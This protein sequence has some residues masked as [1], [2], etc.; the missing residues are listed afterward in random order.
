MSRSYLAAVALYAVW[1]L[2]GINRP[3]IAA[4]SYYSTSWIKVTDITASGVT[5]ETS[6]LDLPSRSVTAGVYNPGEVATA[7]DQVC[8]NY[9]FSASGPFQIDITF[10]FGHSF[11]IAPGEYA[12]ATSFIQAW[13][14]GSGTGFQ[15][16]SSFFNGAWQ[17][18][19]WPEYSWIFGPQPTLTLTGPATCSNLTICLGAWALYDDPCNDNGVIPGPA[20]F[21]L[22]L[23]GLATLSVA[24]RPWYRLTGSA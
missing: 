8:V 19:G 5:W 16:S 23:A 2:V 20:A 13:V 9:T 7:D 4:Y 6:L 3:A 12:S 10:D 24:R 15:T 21:G 14:N 18:Y 11:Q 17:Y 22:C 1:S